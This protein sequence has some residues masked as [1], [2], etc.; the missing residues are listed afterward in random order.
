M[1][2]LTIILATIAAALVGLGYLFY[3]ESRVGDGAALA[4]D[5]V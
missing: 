2:R 4:L 3:L 5:A 1:L